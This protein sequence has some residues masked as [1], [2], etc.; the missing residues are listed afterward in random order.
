MYHRLLSGVGTVVVFRLV[1]TDQILEKVQEFRLSGTW[2]RHMDIYSKYYNY[3]WLIVADQKGDHLEVS[4]HIAMALP[5][6]CHVIA[7]VLPPCCCR[8]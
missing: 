7:V 5:Q 3:H 4:P 8:C 1:D 6:Y 2:P